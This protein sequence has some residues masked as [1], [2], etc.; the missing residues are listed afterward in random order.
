MKVIL[1]SNY[2]MPSPSI[3]TAFLFKEGSDHTMINVVKA[4]QAEFDVR[5]GISEIF[6][7]DSHSGWGFLQE[8]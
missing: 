6:A 2:T 7:E 8:S 4:D 1:K 5:R 3:L